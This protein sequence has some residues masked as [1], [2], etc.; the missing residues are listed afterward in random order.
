M[1][2]VP[3]LDSTEG[4]L[5]STELHNEY[6]PTWPFGPGNQRTMDVMLAPRC[7]SAGCWLKAL[8]LH[9]KCFEHL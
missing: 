9:L 7:A 6:L 8:W 1:E 4:P 3:L 5:Q 2:I